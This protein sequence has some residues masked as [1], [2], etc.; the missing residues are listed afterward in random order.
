MMTSFGEIDP[1]EEIK[2]IEA[3]LK[4]IPEDCP[5][6]AVYRQFLADLKRLVEGAP[7]SR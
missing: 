7:N 4:T 3:H 5:V 2:R 6:A 1:H